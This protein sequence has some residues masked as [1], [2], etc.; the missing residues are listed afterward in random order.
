MS[1]PG[2]SLAT[3]DAISEVCSVI[4]GDLVP[5]IRQAMENP[6]ESDRFVRVALTAIQQN[7]ALLE[8]K[9]HTGS[10]YNSVIQC[11]QDGLL[12]DGREAAFV[13]WYDKKSGTNKIRYQPMIGGFR[14][15]AANHGF[16]LEAHVVY[17]ADEFDYELGL[18]PVLKHKPAPLGVDPGRMIGAY[19]VARHPDHSEPF[20]DVMRQSEIEQVRAVSKQ[21]DGDLW[22]K[23]TGEA[24]KK[25][26]ARRLFKTLP[27]ALDPRTSSMLSAD[28]A[29]FD[30]A[31]VPALANLPTVDLAD[32]EPE[33]EVVLDMD[34]VPF[35]EDR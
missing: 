10:L 6:A 22:T 2:T 4:S 20:V 13:R 25:T 18:S 8:G 17:E 9:V 27:L 15:R 7:P 11:A 30:V 29:G 3:R 24:W 14:K 19:A 34:D 12:P 21:P 26:V 35:G 33:Q 31:P 28:D 32:E 16:S 23:W 5:K 1:T